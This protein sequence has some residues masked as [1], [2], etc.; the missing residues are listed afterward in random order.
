MPMPEPPHG[1]QWRIVLPKKPSPTSGKFHPE[2]R[3]ENLSNLNAASLNF[4]PYTMI[5]NTDD[6]EIIVKVA[7]YLVEL[8][9]A[10]A[11]VRNN[12]R[13]KALELS[14]ALGCQVEA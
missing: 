14:E 8:A 11:E 6:P 5:S 12:R 1:Y 2:V 9:Q 7:E 10:D 3:L 4:R 13:L